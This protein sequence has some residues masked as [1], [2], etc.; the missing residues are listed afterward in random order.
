MNE[1][2]RQ[3]YQETIMEHNKTPRN[4]GKPEH[5][6]HKA[7]GFNPLCGDHLHVYLEMDGDVIKKVYFD[8]SG[9]AISKSSASMMTQ[10]LSGKTREEAEALFL[11]FQRMVSRAQ[12]ADF[13]E[14]ELG[15]LAVFSGINEFPARVKCAILS[16]HTVRSALAGK[17]DSVST[18]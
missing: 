18:E 15:K 4:F 13:D 17:Q 3:L 5:C 10:I 14:N 16:W 6:D 7:E 8:G 1:E 11:S 12:G 2:L 9:C